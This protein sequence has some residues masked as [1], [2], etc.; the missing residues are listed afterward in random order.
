MLLKVVL[1]GESSNNGSLQTTLDVLVTPTQ[2]TG[3][4]E[5]SPTLQI[6]A[7][8]ESPSGPEDQSLQRDLQSTTQ[9]D[10][11]NPFLNASGHTLP[12]STTIWEREDT[13]KASYVVQNFKD[14]R[15]TGALSHSIEMTLRDCN[16]CARQHRIM[17]SQKADY[18]VNILDGPARTYFFNNASDLM[19]FDVMA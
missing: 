7:L 5:K 9:L 8:R 6:S 11:F 19:P 1:N 3:K 13:R 16:I 18:F 17:K 14:N 12:S 10:L 2:A 4:N 15:F